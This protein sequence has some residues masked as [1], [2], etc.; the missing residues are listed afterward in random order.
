M[1]RPG[2]MCYFPHAMFYHAYRVVAEGKD[3]IGSAVISIT[4]LRSRY[5]ASSHLCERI[6]HVQEVR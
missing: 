3:L 1:F 5:A 6:Y 4:M 2:D